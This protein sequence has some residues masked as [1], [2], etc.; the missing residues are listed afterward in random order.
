MRDRYTYEQIRRATQM[1]LDEANHYTD[2]QICDRTEVSIS[3][4]KEW[5]RRWREIYRKPTLHIYNYEILKRISNLTY[6]VCPEVWNDWIDEID[7]RLDEIN[8]TATTDKIW[9]ILYEIARNINAHY[10]ERLDVSS[11]MI[12]RTVQCIAESRRLGR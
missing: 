4:I 10:S 12:E 9:A 1:M 11:E 6:G 5:R 7:E 2:A 3:R 8:G